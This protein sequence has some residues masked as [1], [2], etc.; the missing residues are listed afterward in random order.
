[1]WISVVLRGIPSTLAVHPQGGFRRN[2]RRR[3]KT[4]RPD[5]DGPPRGLL[6]YSTAHRDVDRELGSH[7][8]AN[9]DAASRKPRISDAFPPR[10]SLADIAIA[11]DRHLWITHRR[12]SL[13]YVRRPPFGRVP[14]DGRG[15][16]QP[17]GFPALAANPRDLEAVVHVGSGP[18]CHPRARVEHRR[19]RAVAVSTDVG[20]AR[21]SLR[22]RCFR[23]RRALRGQYPVALSRRIRPYTT[24]CERL[25]AELER[26][27][28]AL[29]SR[30]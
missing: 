9:D 24:N 6:N 3:R 7:V 2:R 23:T 29:S 10:E 8:N 17:R 16:I 12:T 4:P 28:I 11:R 18:R 26:R 27:G 15:Q 19:D 22:S 13:R 1:M 20:G 21:P 14:A 30:R 5:A 25:Q